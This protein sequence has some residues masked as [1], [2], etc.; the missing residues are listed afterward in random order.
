MDKYDISS[1]LR[2]LGL[3]K[4][5]DTARFYLKYIAS[6]PSIRR[7]RKENKGVKLPPPYYVYETFNLNYYSFYTRSIE[8][9]RWLVSWFEKYK[10]PENV[11]ILDWGC[12]PGRIIRHLPSLLPSSCE[13]FGSDYNKKYISWCSKNIPGIQF[14]T[15][16]LQPPLD[17]ESDF[18]DII[19]GISIF[20]HLSEEMHY[21]WFA[22]LLRVCKPGGIIFLTLHGEAFKVKLGDAER[23]QFEKGELVV[24]A[25]TKEGHRTFG[26]FHPLKFV[27]KLAGKNEILLHKPGVVQ[28]GKPAQDVWIIRKA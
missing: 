27:R 21:K 6:Y 28:D 22:E 17:F 12:G 8:S 15:N 9:A 10:N 14:K 1:A 13:L 18:F 20:T 4:A 3:I 19:Y 23:Q 16:E 7:F 25:N 2:K 11:K 24:K 5:G 26:A